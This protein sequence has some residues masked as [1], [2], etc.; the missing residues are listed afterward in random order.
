MTMAK[1]KSEKLAPFADLIGEVPAEK[2]AEMAGVSVEEVEEASA[3]VE[4]T[5]APDPAEERMVMLAAAAESLLAQGWKLRDGEL[6]APAPQV[7]T[8][9]PAKSLVIRLKAPVRYAITN[10]KGKRVEIVLPRS[11]YRGEM[12]VRVLEILG[13]RHRHLVE[14]L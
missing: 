3:P 6:V 10:A 12:A 9:A 5:T 11:V 7:A 8:G 2:I 1:T 13:E 14:R 4:Q